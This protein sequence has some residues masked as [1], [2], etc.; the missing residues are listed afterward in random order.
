MQPNTKRQVGWSICQMKG[1]KEKLNYR[2]GIGRQFEFDE[3]NDDCKRVKRFANFVN[4]SN[5]ILSF[6]L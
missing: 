6:K 5:Y 4:F 3:W 2:L 1:D